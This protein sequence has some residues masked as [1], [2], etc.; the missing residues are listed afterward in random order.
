MRKEEKGFTLIELLVALPLLTLILA[1]SVAAFYVVT[2]NSINGIIQNNVQEEARWAVDM[3]AREIRCS[4]KGSLE[5]NN[6]KQLNFIN[7]AGKEITYSLG[8]SSGSF[9][10]TLYRKIVTDSI[11]NPVNDQTKAPVSNLQFIPLPIDAPKPKGVKIV[12]TIDNQIV[13]TNVWQLNI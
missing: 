3:M 10:Q 9:T 4:Q 5:I 7:D 12:L 2:H 13:Q 8:D 1:C 6:N 11:E